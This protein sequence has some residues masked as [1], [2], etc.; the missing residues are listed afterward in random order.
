MNS[1]TERSLVGNT[2]GSSDPI[3]RKEPGEYLSVEEQ[4]EWRTKYE[5]EAKLIYAGHFRQSPELSL[6]LREKYKSPIFG[7]MYMFD[8]LSKLSECIDPTDTELYCVNQ[9]I[10]TLQVVVGME[11]DGIKDETLLLT[12]LVHDLGKITEIAGEAPEYVNGP[13]E[14][15]G[16]NVPGSGLDNTIT[17]WNHDEYAYEKIKEHVPDHVA[18]LTR[19]HSLRFDMVKEFMDDRDWEYYHKYLGLFR[20]YDLGTKSIYNLPRK[21]LIDYKYLIDKYFPDKIEL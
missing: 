4:A 18:W 1:R 12:A 3:F 8:A 14:P 16:D 6:E 21:K 9:L 7:S 17:T 10:H 11:D 15:I 13:N 2:F 19:F 5:D 20:K